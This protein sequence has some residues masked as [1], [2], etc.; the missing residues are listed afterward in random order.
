[1]LQINSMVIVTICKGQIVKND[2][3]NEPISFQPAFISVEI[4][5]LLYISSRDSFI[6]KTPKV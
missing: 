6:P 1:M 3:L 2:E 5:V 4:N